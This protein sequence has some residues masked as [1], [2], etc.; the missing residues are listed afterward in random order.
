MFDVVG[1]LAEEGVRRIVL[2]LQDSV[3]KIALKPR[4]CT[5]SPPGTIVRVYVDCLFYPREGAYVRQV[6]VQLRVR[7][8]PDVVEVQM[9]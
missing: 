6:R 8:H 1:N 9:R 5:R 2:P 3:R 4:S 7:M